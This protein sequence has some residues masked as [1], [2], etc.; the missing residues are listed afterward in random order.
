[1]STSQR[2]SAENIQADAGVLRSTID[3]YNSSCDH[4]HD[5][6]FAKEQSYLV[7][8]RTPPYYGMRCYPLSLAAI[9]GR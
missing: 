1:M 4:G 9:E 5:A 6:V 7:P 3:Q 8:L 2:T